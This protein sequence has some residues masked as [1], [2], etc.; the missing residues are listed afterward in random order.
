[1]IIAWVAASFCFYLI[2]F[3]LKYLPGNIFTNTYA[4]SFSDMVATVASAPL[5]DK[6]GIKWSLIMSFG[7]A[8]VGAFVICIWGWTAGGDWTLPILVIFTKFG[9]S[10]AFNVIYLGNGVLF[11][12][13][14]TA[15]SM[16]I[17]NMFARTSSI[18]APFVAEIDGVTPLWI[19]CAFSA[20]ATVVA[21]GL[22]KPDEAT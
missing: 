18:A 22:K 3:E 2:G 4:S 10:A 6:C 5:F 8:T 21:F 19:C 13:L 11:P 14:F 9:V 16:G 20:L 1:M 17:C 12:T 15:T 7:M